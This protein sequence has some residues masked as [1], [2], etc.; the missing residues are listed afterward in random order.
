MF[1]I[2]IIK[3]DY[4]RTIHSHDLFRSSVK[5]STGKPSLKSCHK[6]TVSALASSSEDEEYQG[7]S[8]K[9]CKIPKVKGCEKAAGGLCN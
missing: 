7:I 6:R 4:Y 1:V 2:S 8:V 3:Y 9:A 5:S